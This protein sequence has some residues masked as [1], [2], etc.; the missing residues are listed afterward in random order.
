MTTNLTEAEIESLNAAKTR[1]ASG[2]RY[3]SADA[4][5]GDRHTVRTLEARAIGKRPNEL[6]PMGFWFD[7]QSN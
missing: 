6:D 1:L 3:P 7:M 4:Y 5:Y 2:E